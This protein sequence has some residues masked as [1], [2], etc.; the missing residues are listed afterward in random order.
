[1]VSYFLNNAA[2]TCIYGLKISENI[3]I[4]HVFQSRAFFHLSINLPTNVCNIVSR[5]NP[6]HGLCEA[7][8]YIHTVA[9]NNPGNTCYLRHEKISCFLQPS[10]SLTPSS[11]TLSSSTLVSNK[12]FYLVRS[13][14]SNII[15]CN[16]Q[17]VSCSAK[18]CLFWIFLM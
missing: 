1:M 2:K 3:E 14:P 11:L 9:V 13:L 10:T 4:G 16:S 8:Q 6:T 12:P 17:Q 5:I 18:F 15:S 7:S